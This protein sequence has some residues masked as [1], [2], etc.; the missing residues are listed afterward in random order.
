MSEA[1]DAEVLAAL[2]QAGLCPCAFRQ[3]SNLP[4]PP[5]YRATYRIDLTD[6]R[7][8]KARRLENAAAAGELFRIRRTLPD[9]FVPAF[10]QHGR[11]LLEEWV[12]GE[13]LGDLPPGP[14]RL[15]EAATLLAALHA[16]VRLDGKALHQLRSTAAHRDL[17]V[18]RLRQLA[19]AGVLGPETAQ[20][21]DQA[22]RRL[23]P[24]HAVFG[25]V[26]LD[27]CGEN[28]VIDRQRGLRVVDNERLGVDALGFDL[29]RAWYRWSLPAAAW[30]EFQSVYA[31]RLPVADPVLTLP[32]WRLVAAAG[33]AAV[34]WRYSPDRAEKPLRCL[35]L[36][37]KE[38]VR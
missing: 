4:S 21:L 37:A 6:G 8:I 18:Q 25:L 13:D 2:A 16:R 30:E 1:P 3:L 34:R 10:A 15:A 12:P 9:A 33:A 36:L 29:A 26:H 22:L 38:L 14:E 7:T 31:A 24:R 11:V 28:M 5:Y 35:H 19:A 23:D 27:F 20:D 32:F 17:A